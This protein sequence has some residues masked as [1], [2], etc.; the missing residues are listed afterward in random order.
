MNL[1][2]PKKVIL[3]AFFM[4][5]FFISCLKPIHRSSLDTSQHTKPDPDWID[6]TELNIDIENSVEEYTFE[7]I[8]EERSTS[9]KTPLQHDDYLQQIARRHSLDMLKHNYFKHVNPKGMTV[10]ERIMDE[11]RSILFKCAGENIWRM[12][13]QHAYHPFTTAEIMMNDL[14]NSEHHRAN[15]LSESY[16][17][18]GLGVVHS[19]EFTCATQVFAQILISFSPPVPRILKQGQTLFINKTGKNREIGIL[20]RFDL[21]DQKSGSVSGTPQSCEYGRITVPRGEYILRLHFR[22]ADGDHT[23]YPGPSVTVK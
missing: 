22:T 7:L 5:L 10:K 1:N 15:I 17:H 18:M 6:E 9:G 23:I 16:T 14:M 19:G 3:F 11:Y 20:E 2:C 21:W 12:K 13:N 8:N 4:A